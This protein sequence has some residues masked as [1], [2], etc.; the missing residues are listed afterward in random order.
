MLHLKK[1]EN[2]IQLELKEYKIPFEVEV[3]DTKKAEIIDIER[4]IDKFKRKEDPNYKGAFHEKKKRPV[5]NKRFQNSRQGK[6][7]TSKSRRKR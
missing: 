3:P 6:S 7:R 1:V 5:E 4:Q 2:L